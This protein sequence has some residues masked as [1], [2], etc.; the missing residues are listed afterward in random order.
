MYRIFSG[1]GGIASTAILG[2]IGFAWSE[3]RDEWRDLKASISE[4]RHELD[5]QPTPIEFE[6]MREKVEA[7]NDRLIRIEARFEKQ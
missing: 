4:I 6:R 3:V 2:I 1:I 7:I 5:Q